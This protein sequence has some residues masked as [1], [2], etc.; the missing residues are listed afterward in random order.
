MKHW[1]L[2]ALCLLAAIG[3]DAR[4]YSHVAEAQDSTSITNVSTLRFRGRTA[5]PPISLPG[6]AIIYLDNGSG[7]LLASQDAGDYAALGGGGTFGSGVLQ[8]PNITTTGSHSF[9]IMDPNLTT[10]GSFA[11]Y[12]GNANV[13]RYAE[14]DLIL[15][16]TS[17]T[18]DVNLK[19][20]GLADF[21]FS[22][23]GNLSATSFTGDGSGLTN[24]A[25]SAPLKDSNGNTAVAVTATGS[26]VN[27][28]N[29]TDAAAGGMVT[30]GTAGAS[31]TIP[32]KLAA[33]GGGY[34]EL[35][36]SGNLV[37]GP[38]ASGQQIIVD[39]TKGAL[40][41]NL[42]SN[43]YGGSG[44]IQPIFQIWSDASTTANPPASFIRLEFQ[45]GY[46]WPIGPGFRNLFS[47]FYTE[48]GDGYYGALGGLSG[49]YDDTGEADW[50]VNDMNEMFVY[51]PSQF[52]QPSMPAP[53]LT[54]NGTGGSTTYSYVIVPVGPY[55]GPT[56]GASATATIGGGN[57]TL[58]G[59]NSI[60]LSWQAVN[61]TFGVGANPVTSVTTMNANSGGTYNIYRTAGGGSQ[62]L[63][64]SVAAGAGLGSTVTFTDTG[65]A[66]DSATA[67]YNSTSW[68]TAPAATMAPGATG[69]NLYIG[70]GVG[71]QYFTIVS[72]SVAPTGTVTI[73]GNIGG[74]PYTKTLTA[75]TN[76]TLGSNNTAAQL[77]VTATSLAIAI[78]AAA[79]TPLILMVRALA[80]GP[81]VFIEPVNSFNGLTLATSNSGAWTVTANANG[82]VN[83][84][85]PEISQSFTEA[86]LPGAPVAGSRVY[87]S[88]CGNV[89]DDSHAV[90]TVVSSGGHGA[91]VQYLNG[92]WRTMD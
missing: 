14:W 53:A 34:L 45:D 60:T 5:P 46:A 47:S 72:N 79:N 66:G 22:A 4:F 7:Q 31:S 13:T 83:L 10:S 35:D 3:L 37:W 92:S 24:V 80:V 59:T 26:A 70:G 44:S 78:N 43:S 57:A 63:I 9:G 62:G 28:V 29:V 23:A 42:N 40:S 69:Q 48:T 20:S 15:G 65:L 71:S 11:T 8:A 16:T 86:N 54:V 84:L 56:M 12:F 76:F 90:G 21:G 32:L 55:N 25:A 38:G 81:Y 85:T 89:A 87:C 18:D 2:V 6:Q 64:G 52:G 75:G 36:A 1:V 88:D 39:R 68:I 27:Y 91:E 58:S 61:T 77:A 67:P 19:V 73:S 30:I 82:N 50:E 49:F 41:L 33:K 17:A 74:F 51:G